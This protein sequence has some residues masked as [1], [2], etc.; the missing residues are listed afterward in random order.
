MVLIHPVT[1]LENKLED[2]EEETT[3][4]PSETP[5]PAESADETPATEDP[6][7]DASF[8]SESIYQKLPSPKSIKQRSTSMQFPSPPARGGDDVGC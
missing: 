2:I 3:P 4:T 5:K 7:M 6:A 1:E 8:M